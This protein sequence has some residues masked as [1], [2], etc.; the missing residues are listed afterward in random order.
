MNGASGQS[1]A[2]AGLSP[3]QDVGIGA[4]Y[5]GDLL[6]DVAHRST[7]T[8]D[9]REPI[10]LPKLLTQPMVLFHQPSVLGCDWATVMDAPRC[11][12][13]VETGDGCGNGDANCRADTAA[14]ACRITRKMAQNSRGILAGQPLG[15]VH[16]TRLSK[17]P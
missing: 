6:A 13:T 15:W 2:G 5:L 16:L 3:E 14:G 12:E 1:F 9:L 17:P 10:A 11:H 8:H 4:R 7:A